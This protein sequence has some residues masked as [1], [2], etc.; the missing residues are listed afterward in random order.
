MDTTRRTMKEH[1]WYWPKANVILIDEGKRLY[2][3]DSGL[4]II[5]KKRDIKS[6]DDFVYLGE[7]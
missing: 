4:E 2:Y 5:I 6:Y 7:L 1:V 3:E